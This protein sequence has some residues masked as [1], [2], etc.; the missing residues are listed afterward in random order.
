MCLPK[1]LPRDRVI[2]AVPRLEVNNAVERS[3]GEISERSPMCRAAELNVSRGE[4]LVQDRHYVG[5]DT[6]GAVESEGPC[7][8][9][10][11]RDAGAIPPIG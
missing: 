10:S 11:Q 6:R 5:V 8:L 2:V 1:R 7:L 9:C 4:G 3:Q